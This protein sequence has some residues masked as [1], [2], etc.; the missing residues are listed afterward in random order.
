MVGNKVVEKT[1]EGT[2][3]AYQGVQEVLCV[4]FECAGEGNRSDRCDAV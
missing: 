1:D 4:L 3:V 2:R